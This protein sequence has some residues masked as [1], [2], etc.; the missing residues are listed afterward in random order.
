MTALTS[1]SIAVNSFSGPIPKELGNLKELTMLAFGSNNFS[2]TLPPELGNLVKLKELYM[3]SCRFS[4]EIPSTFAKLI[5][6]Q[7][8]WASDTAFSGKIPAFIGNWTKLTVL[9][10]QG[11]SF[12]GP[13]P[14]SFSQLTSLNDLRISDIS[15]VS[16]S[17]DFIRNLKN[18]AEL[19]LWNALINGSIPSD[20]GE[21]QSIVT[22]NLGFNNL[23]GQLPSSLFNMSSLTYLFL[24]N[25]SL[26]GPLPSQK[27]NRLQTIDLSY[28]YLSGSLPQWVSTISQ[29]NLVVNNFTFGSSNITLSGLN[30]L[31][32]NFPCNTPRYTNFSIKCGGPQMRG[33]DGI[34]YEADQDLALGLAKFYVTSTQ[35][36]AVSNVGLFATRNNPSFVETTL[37][38]V[39]GT[40]VTPALFQTSRVSPGS[41]RYYGLGLQNGPY[42]V[43]LQFAETV[44]ASR[45]NQTWESL[46]RR[47]FDIYIQ[48]NLIRKDFDISKEAGGVNRAIKRPF[49]VNVTENYLDIHLFWA[50]KGTCCIPEEDFTPTVS[51]LPPTTPGKKSRTGLIVGI[52]VPV[53]VVSLLLLF[54]VLYMRRKKSEKDDDEDL[55]GLGPRPNT[56]SYAELRAATEDFNPS[57]KLGEG[58]YGP[59]YKGTLSD[60]RSLDQALFGRN[61]LHLDW[62][63]RFNILLG[64]A[65]GLAYLHEESRPRIVHRDVKASN[66]LLD[67]ELSPKIS[68]FGLA[69]LYD[70]EKTHISTRV[71]GTIGYLAPE[72]A[73]RGHLTEKADVFGFGVVALEILSGRPNSDNNLDPEKIYL[74]EWAWTLHEKDQSLGLVDPRLT[75]FDE[76]DATRLIKA[77]LLCTQASPMMRPSMSRVVAMLSGDIE[78]STV[79]SKPSYLTDWNFKDVTTSSFLVDDDTSSTER[80]VVL[81]H[82]PEGSTTTASPGIDPAPSPVNVTGSMLTGIIGEGR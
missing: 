19:V 74:L 68:D 76:N 69:K 71:A 51:G 57:N 50:G 70:D 17:L 78:A 66:I 20:I 53:G 13:I 77:A 33:I 8:L 34:L 52:A 40:D 64:T 3:N 25:N 46:G 2:G 1:L 18:L 22:M 21:Y 11:N 65:R 75:E 49:K 6:M 7:I 62:P 5:N 56:F 36:W 60:G 39:T 79:M 37:T 81:N 27:S 82:Q 38:E 80:N 32:R 63:T 26:S 73:M 31:Q 4:G 54:A 41:L 24:G 44:F 58:G 29:L 16:S 14:T 48:G 15:N 67:A 61:D 35:N 10:L 28:N 55:L 59:V 30:C 47:V 23:T 45:A 9:R 12:E 72:Y 43:T 42:T